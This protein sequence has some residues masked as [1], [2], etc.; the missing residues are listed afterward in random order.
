M[1]KE[2]L[3]KIKHAP[4]SPAQADR[5]RVVLERQALWRAR[6]AAKNAA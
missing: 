4:L 3:R 6:R 5:L 1:Y 2:L